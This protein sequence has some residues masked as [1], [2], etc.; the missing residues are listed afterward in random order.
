MQRFLSCSFTSICAV[1]LYCLLTKSF[2][3]L[4][5]EINGIS[6]LESLY[7]CILLN[8]FF[9]RLKQYI[10]IPARLSHL[11]ISH[12]L[13]TTG[14]FFSPFF[15]NFIGENNFYLDLFM[16]ANTWYVQRQTEKNQR[17][18]KSVGTLPRVVFF[19]NRFPDHTHGI[20]PSS[21]ESECDIYSFT[22]FGM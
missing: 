14:H 10:I 18:R 8:Y 7:L 16:M 3:E 12:I 6:I 19:I 4:Q 2:L 5:S 1:F 9:K 22:T 13:S 17:Q 20:L 15:A 21:Y 11:A